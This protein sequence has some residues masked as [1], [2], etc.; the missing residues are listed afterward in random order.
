MHHHHLAVQKL[1]L[2]FGL[3]RRRMGGARV[4][5]IKSSSFVSGPGLGKLRY[6]Q[7]SYCREVVGYLIPEWMRFTESGRQHRT[8]DMCLTG[9]TLSLI[10]SPKFVLHRFLDACVCDRCS[11]VLLKCYSIHL[12]ASFCKHGDTNC[13][14]SLILPMVLAE[15]ESASVNSGWMDRGC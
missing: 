8:L 15:S 14:V 13:C 3:I 10:P 11:D 9:R 5:E 12:K 7:G 6:C 1:P 4:P 2:A